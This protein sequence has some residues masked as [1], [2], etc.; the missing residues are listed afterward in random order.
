MGFRRRYTRS[1][2]KDGFGFFFWR[3]NTLAD[4]YYYSSVKKSESPGGTCAVIQEAYLLALQTTIISLF[5]EIIVVCWKLVTAVLDSMR[6][7]HWKKW[8][9]NGVVG[10][11]RQNSFSLF[12]FGSCSW[13]C[14]LVCS[15]GHCQNLGKNK[16]KMATSLRK[17]CEIARR[18]GGCGECE[19]ESRCLWSEF[20]SSQSVCFLALKYFLFL[21]PWFTGSWGGSFLLLFWNVSLPTSETEN[22]CCDRHVP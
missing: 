3:R 15:D 19:L 8:I 21:P 11:K 5:I 16:A 4:L 22:N 10:K 12:R 17:I 14:C 1:E 6:V 2:N 13:F 7:L 20:Q 9:S 18:L